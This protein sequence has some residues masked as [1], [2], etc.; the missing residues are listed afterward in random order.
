MQR[1]RPKGLGRTPPGVRELKLTG[2]G[3]AHVPPLHRTPP[4]MR[5]L[6]RRAVLHHDKW[7]MS[8]PSRGA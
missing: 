8:H 2:V 7:R 1:L 5:E 3:V 6:K 4:G